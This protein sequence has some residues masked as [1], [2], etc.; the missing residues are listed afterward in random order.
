MACAS[1]ER[2]SLFWNYE[3][4]AM[5]RKRPPQ[6]ATESQ[7]SLARRRGK[8]RLN[9]GYVQPPTTPTPDSQARPTLPAQPPPTLSA[10]LCRLMAW[11]MMGCVNMGS[12]ISLCLRQGQR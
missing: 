6:R 1:N 9:T 12:S 4:P 2:R 8:E 10:F 3:L 5:V 7:G 11:Y